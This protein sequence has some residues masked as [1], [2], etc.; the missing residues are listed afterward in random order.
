MKSTTPWC[1]TVLWSDLV[2]LLVIVSRISGLAVVF[3]CV[4]VHRHRGWGKPSEW[5]KKIWIFLNLALTSLRILTSYVD[6]FWLFL[7]SLGNETTDLEQSEPF[8]STVMA[9]LRDLAGLRVL[10]YHTQYQSV[11]PHATS[12][13]LSLTGQFH[14]LMYSSF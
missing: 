4:S 9:S 1:V 6:Y 8:F 13:F 11:I 5:E 3:V 14:V 2:R 7:R 12:G 10:I